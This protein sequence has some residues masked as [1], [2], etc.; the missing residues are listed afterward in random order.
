MIQSSVNRPTPTLQD[1]KRPLLP[2]SS[3]S[4]TTKRVSV[5]NLIDLIQT[6]AAYVTRYGDAFLEPTRVEPYNKSIDDNATAVVRAHTEAAHKAKRADRATYETSLQ[7]TTQ[8]VLTVVADNWVGEFR[9]TETIYT[10]VALKDL[11]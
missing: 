1:F 11:L 9:D 7:E 2:S 6:G 5:H 10:E 4:H 3:I 8:F